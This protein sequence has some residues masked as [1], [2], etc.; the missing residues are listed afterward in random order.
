MNIQHGRNPEKNQAYVT[1][2]ADDQ[3]HL[4][5]LRRGSSEAE[6]PHGKR[7]AAGSIPAPGSFFGRLGIALVCLSCVFFMCSVQDIFNL[8][9]M[10]MASLGVLVGLWGRRP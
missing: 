3:E 1:I 2:T 6:Q 9:K 10:W 8:P 5:Q 7:Q 4:G